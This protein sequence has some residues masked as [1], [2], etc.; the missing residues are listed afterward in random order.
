MHT[1]WGLAEQFLYRHVWWYLSIPL[2]YKESKQWFFLAVNY[3]CLFWVCIYFALYLT[4]CKNVL[5]FSSIVYVSFVDRLQSSISCIE[6]S[7]C[8]TDIW[9]VI[10][11]NEIFLH[12]CSCIIKMTPLN[13]CWNILQRMCMMLAKYFHCFLTFMLLSTHQSSNC[14]ESE[15][16][17]GNFKALFVILSQLKHIWV[18]EFKCRVKRAGNWWMQPLWFLLPSLQTKTF[19][20]ILGFQNF[21][22]YIEIT[23]EYAEICF[24]SCC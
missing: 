12:K 10:I 5:L 22:L 4:S 21:Y 15:T 23:L 7:V 18:N 16:L 9:F 24:M 2:S 1:V 11:L 19:L 17:T 8:Q 3:P 20:C 14:S 6:F 13:Y